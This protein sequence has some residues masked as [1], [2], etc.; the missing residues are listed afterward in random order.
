MFSR[1][2]SHHERKKMP[3]HICEVGT[4]KED[5][6]LEHV[7]ASHHRLHLPS[8]FFDCSDLFSSLNLEILSK[9]RNMFRLLCFIVYTW[10]E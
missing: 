10:P 9:F 6:I 8:S 4:L 3:C 7:L 1:A 2:I 5:S